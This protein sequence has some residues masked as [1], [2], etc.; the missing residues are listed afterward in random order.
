M[1]SSNDTSGSFV[2]HDINSLHELCYIF[3]KMNLTAEKRLK[4]VQTFLKFASHSNSQLF[5]GRSKNSQ[6]MLDILPNSLVVVTNFEL[7]HF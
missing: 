6:K 1:T 3:T 5:D 4:Y 7:A 2:D